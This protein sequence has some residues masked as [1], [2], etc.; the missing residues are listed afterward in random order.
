MNNETEL[1]NQLIESIEQK[2]LIENHSAWGHGTPTKELADDILKNGVIVNPAYSLTE[3]G[4]PLTDSTKKNSDNAQAI[5]NSAMAW[6]HKNH[7]FVVIIEIPHGLRKSQITETI[8]IE[9]K[10][11]TRLPNRFIKGY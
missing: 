3:I 8:T 11:R 9:G 1:K 4:V 2:L 5:F 10:E 7:K 6:P